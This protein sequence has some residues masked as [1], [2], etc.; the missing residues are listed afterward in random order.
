MGALDVAGAED[1]S[2]DR[3][4]QDDD[5]PSKVSTSASPSR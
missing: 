4:G 5:S 1:V 2:E 3:Q